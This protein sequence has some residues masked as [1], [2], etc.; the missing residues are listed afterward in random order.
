MKMEENRNYRRQTTGENTSSG[1]GSSYDNSSEC[2]NSN[3][4]S[5]SNSNSGG[6]GDGDGGEDKREN[7]RIIRTMVNSMAL[8]AEM[9]GMGSGTGNS[10]GTSSG[11]RHNEFVDER[12]DTS[13][14]SPYRIS[15]RNQSRRKRRL[16]PPSSSPTTAT[17]TTTTITTPER[18]V[19]RSSQETYVSETMPSLPTITKEDIHT[20]IDLDSSAPGLIGISPD[21]DFAFNDDTY[22]LDHSQQQQTAANY[23]TDESSSSMSQE[24]RFYRSRSWA[25]QK[26][27][28]VIFS[29]PGSLRSFCIETYQ[30]AREQSLLNTNNRDTDTDTHTDN[31]NDTREAQI[32]NDEYDDNSLDERRLRTTGIPRSIANNKNFFVSITSDTFN[33]CLDLTLDVSFSTLRVTG[34]A[35]HTSFCVVVNVWDGVTRSAYTIITRPFNVMGKTREVFVSGIQSV[36]TGVGSASS[37][38][39][40]RLS[41]KNRSSPLSSGL[42]YGGVSQ[43]QG[44]NHNNLRRIRSPA[45]ITLVNEKLLRKLNNLTSAAPVVPYTELDDN[46]GGLS[47]HAKSR[48]QRMMH[49]DVSLR[50]FVATVQLRESFKKQTHPARTCGTDSV[51]DYDADAGE[52]STTS[53]PLEGPFMCTP[54]SFPPTPAS[55]AHVLKRGSRFADDVVFL[56]RDQ[57]RVHDGLESSN[58]RTREMAEALTHGK[59]LAV[60]DAD[61]A[62]AGIDLSCGQHVATKVGPL[63]Y[64]SLRS[65]VPILRNCF[66]YFEMTVLGRSGGVLQTGMATLS[67]GL[68]TKEMPTDTLVGAWK[69]SVGLCTTGQI[70]ISGQWCSPGPDPTISSFGDRETIGCLV[71]LDDSSAFETWDG[72]MIT[73]TVTF[74]INGRIVSPHVPSLPTIS[75]FDR[76]PATSIPVVGTAVPPSFT[77]PL[78][79]PA[80]EELYPTLTLHS[81]GTSVMCRFSAGDVV[82]RSRDAIGAPKK[83]PVYAVD[84]SL[85]L[86]AEE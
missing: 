81:P 32:C 17:T 29:H 24:Q 42:V 40:H 36:A 3:I 72:V 12:N 69:G 46:D 65:M 18:E 78:L 37:I 76:R 56:A 75:G 7:E 14:R 27:A 5:N 47:R 50:P 45:K 41:A 6:D 38:A 49:Y 74:N 61:D 80:E 70:L 15:A 1:S 23:E 52:A 77:L 10:I 63:L 54:Q 21:T 71:C 62:S 19:P 68:S 84:G 55:R 59:R 33:V 53:S 13:R 35:L 43:H 86:T 39:L 83:V 30:A 4:N 25:K 64:C 9:S 26:L 28:A 57:L 8:L 66:V 60:F 20:P 82:S 58:E 44:N 31:Y 11:R 16:P 2:Y 34:M 48:V 85:V 79:V 73:A 67:F 51:V 22:P